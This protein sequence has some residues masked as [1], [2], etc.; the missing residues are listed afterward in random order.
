MN[1]GLCT[2]SVCMND[3]VKTW[4]ICSKVGSD[5]KCFSAPLTISNDPLTITFTCHN[6]AILI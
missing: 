5:H 4:T 2:L 1:L 3:S 6:L